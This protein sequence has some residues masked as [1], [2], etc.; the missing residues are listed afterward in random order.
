MRVGCRSGYGECVGVLE[1]WRI[2]DGA[3]CWSVE[4]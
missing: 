4:T 3:E 1:V 2:V